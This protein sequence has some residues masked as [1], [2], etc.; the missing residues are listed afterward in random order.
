MCTFTPLEQLLFLWLSDTSLGGM[1]V[2]LQI[3]QSDRRMVEEGDEEKAYD[4]GES[5]SSETKG[6]TH[7]AMNHAE[8]P[9]TTYNKA[10]GDTDPTFR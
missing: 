9:R 4:G 10:Q 7:S 5:E 1:A 3:Q 6:A 2:L 8:V